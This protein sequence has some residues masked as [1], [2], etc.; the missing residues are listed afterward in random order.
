MDDRTWMHHLRKGDYSH[1]FRQH[2]KDD[3]LADP[4]HEVEQDKS[5]SAAESRKRIRAK[6]E[7]RYTATE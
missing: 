1:W 6:I 3:G 7:E 2:I 5:L 4:A